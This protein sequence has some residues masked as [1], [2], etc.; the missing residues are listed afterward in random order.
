MIKRRAFIVEDLHAEG[1]REPIVHAQ[2]AYVAIRATAATDNVRAGTTG[3][4]SK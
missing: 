3:L 2:R 1:R 4:S